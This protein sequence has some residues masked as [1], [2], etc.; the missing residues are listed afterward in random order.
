MPRAAVS[1]TVPISSLRSS[2]S[3][4]A[5]ISSTRCPREAASR[6]PPGSKLQ[7]L[8]QVQLAVA[9][10]IGVLLSFQNERCLSM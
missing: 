7:Q 2:P 6:P 9:L 4:T 3:A 5:S 8:A 10:P 1:P